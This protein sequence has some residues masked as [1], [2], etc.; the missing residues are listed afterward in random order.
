MD[1]I[2]SF[3]PDLIFRSRI[4]ET[5]RAL[6]FELKNAR[7]YED[8]LSAAERVGPKIVLLDLNSVSFDLSEL[9]SKLCALASP[10]VVVTFYSHV[11]V[12]LAERA[13][14]AGIEHLFPRSKFFSHLEGILERFGGPDS[15]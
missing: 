13:R 11:D 7:T 14:T 6:G 2:V 1:Q 12:E 15:A 5:V 4:A 3:V 10:P 9:T 8:L